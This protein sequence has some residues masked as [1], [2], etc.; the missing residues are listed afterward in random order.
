MKDSPH[1]ATKHLLGGLLVLLA[2]AAGAFDWRDDAA[3]PTCDNH[4][5]MGQLAWKSR[6]GDWR[7]VNQVAQG[8]RAYAAR[9]VPE[10]PSPQR[11]EI[12]VTSALRASGTATGS[13]T[14]ML[15]AEPGSLRGQADFFSREARDSLVRPRLE[16]KRVDDSRSQLDPAADTLLDC[17]SVTSLGQLPLLSVRADRS[18]LLRFVG[19]AANTSPILSARLVLTSYRQYAGGARVGVYR[20]DMPGER[21]AAAPR[22]GLASRTLLDAGLRGQPSVLFASGFERWPWQFEWRDL[23]P[24]SQAEVVTRDPEL[25][26]EPL[27][28]KAL[29]VRLKRDTH[30]ALDLRLQFGRF[31]IDEPEE[32]YLRYYLRLGSDWNPS[33]DGGKLPGLAGTYGRGGWGHRKADGRNGWSMRGAFAARPGNADSVRGLTA[34]ATLA[35]H[36]RIHEATCETWGWGQGPGAVIENGRW[37]AVEQRVRL[38]TPGRADGEFEAWIDGQQVYRR[39][40]I[41]YRDV[42]E[43]RIETA[44][45]DIYFGGTEKAPADMTLYLDNVVVAREYIGPMA[46]IV[47]GMPGR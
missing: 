23:T 25:G 19:H 12:D 33:T 9:D 4:L 21:P 22:L 26:F 27:D 30:L 1:R 14:L 47:K 42:P 24:R 10:Q 38:N 20:A 34:L 39:D 45:F 29:R 40:S 32:L 5:T 35:C 8:Q 18:S 31:G 41:V 13:V 28:G 6:G 16:L 11:I 3:G 43:L 44:W 15:R 46:G 2:S 37:Y 17:T 7:D 36:A